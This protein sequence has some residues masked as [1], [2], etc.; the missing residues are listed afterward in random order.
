ML[1]VVLPVFW[2]TFYFVWKYRASNTKAKYL[3]DW[4]NNYVAEAIWWGFPF[5][6]ITVLSVLVYKSSHELDP[7][8]R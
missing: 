3:P 6:I 8:S 7:S 1:I 5:A 2:M 4:D